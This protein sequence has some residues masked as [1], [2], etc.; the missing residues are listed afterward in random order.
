MVCEW[1]GFLRCRPDGR[2]CCMMA[3]F[4]EAQ[5]KERLTYVAKGMPQS[6]ATLQDRI[7]AGV[8][9]REGHAMVQV[10]V[11]RRGPVVRLEV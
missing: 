9:C 4:V 3:G 1:C 8:L 10:L 5:M 6:R 7:L 11:E 2:M